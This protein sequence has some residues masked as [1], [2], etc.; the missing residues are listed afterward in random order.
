MTVNWKDA[1]CKISKYFCVRDACW[2][3]S[4]KKLH[5]PTPSEAANILEMAAKLDLVRELLKKPIK[6]H[7][8]IRP[9]LYN[10]L[11]GGALNSSHILG[12]AVDFSCGEDCDLTRQKLLPHLPDLKLRMENLPE[13]NWVHLGNDWVKGKSY[14]FKP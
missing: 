1:T 7:S 11:I 9:R 4:W 6:I 14:F 8:W 13:S 2:L 3:P 12:K 10:L 5:N